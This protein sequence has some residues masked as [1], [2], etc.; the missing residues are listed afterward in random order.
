[1][2]HQKD[3]VSWDRGRQPLLSW[4]VLGLQGQGQAGLFQAE[5]V[6]TELS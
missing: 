2:I 3:F 4:Q 1:M 5:H 6:L